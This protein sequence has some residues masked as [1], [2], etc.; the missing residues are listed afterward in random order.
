[1][2]CRLITCA[3][4]LSLVQEATAKNLDNVYL[5]GSQGY[6]LS[7]P[8]YRVQQVPPSQ[9]A[10]AAAPWHP[11]SPTASAAVMPPRLPIQ[12]FGTWHL[13][14]NSNWE[15]DSGAPYWSW[16]RLYA[17][18]HVG[19]G[20]VSTQ[21]ADPFGVSVFGDTTR[22]PGFLGGGQIGFDWQPLNS[23]W[24]LGVEADASALG[25]DGTATCFAV[26]AIT[27]SP[28]YA[29]RIKI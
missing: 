26:S 12:E 11:F 8:S 2:L 13:R 24:V 7:G 23:P 15:A 14:G 18:A 27:I 29:R 10:G 6:D 9:A 25:G 21:F 19:A 17:G 20:S 4:A 3:A 22:S 5:R 28:D 1:M 16:T